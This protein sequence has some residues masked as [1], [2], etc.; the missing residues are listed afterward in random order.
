MGSPLRSDR[1]GIDARLVGHEQRRIFFPPVE[2]VFLDEQAKP[3]SASHVIP[4]ARTLGRRPVREI[5]T[6]SSGRR[7][8]DKKL[9]SISGASAGISGNNSTTSTTAPSCRPRAYMHNEFPVH[10]AV[11]DRDGRRAD[12]QAGAEHRIGVGLGSCGGDECAEPTRE[13]GEARGRRRPKP[14]SRHSPPA[15]TMGVKVVGPRL[16]ISSGSSCW[17]SRACVG[18]P[19][20]LTRPGAAGSSDDAR[21]GKTTWVGAT[22]VEDPPGSVTPIIGGKRPR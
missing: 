18:W 16:S 9:S 13:G 11:V 1:P 20:R 21:Q 7:V 15:F 17:S 12:R 19:A 8:D 14:G 3:R 22:G 4:G 5:G 2:L 6:H 10:D